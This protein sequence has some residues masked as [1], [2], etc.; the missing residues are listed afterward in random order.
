MTQAT[1]PDHVSM[2]PAE[3]ET[4]VQRAVDEGV[5]RALANLGI[6][7]RSPAQIREW[8]ADMA[9]VRTTREGTA[10]LSASAKATII[11]TITS[12]ILF[13]IYQLFRTPGAGQ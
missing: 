8:H 11:T 10:K 7:N 2:T 6:D 12:G 4:L 1:P 13:L 3:L 9:W 5:T